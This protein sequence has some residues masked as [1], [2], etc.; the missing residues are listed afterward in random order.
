MTKAAESTVPRA[1]RRYL[2]E[3][4]QVVYQSRQ[5]L[6]LVLAALAS[7]VKVM[8][9]GGIAGLIVAHLYLDGRKVGEWLQWLGSAA[10]MLSL[11]AVGWSLLGWYLERLVVTD[12]KVLYATGILNRHVDS[13][14]LSRIDEMSV[15]KPLLGRVLNF[16]RLEVE[17]ASGQMDALY[18]LGYIPSPEEAYRI[19]TEG[20]RRERMREGGARVDGESAHPG[21]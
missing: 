18:G 14:P 3:G 21:E 11:L 12:E 6:V 1:V 20:A 15:R 7:V 16:G 9:F 5:H 10:V 17:N 13:T 2:N 4:E 8:L 19:V